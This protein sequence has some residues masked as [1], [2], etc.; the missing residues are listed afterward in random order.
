MWQKKLK[1]CLPSNTNHKQSQAITSNHKQSQER[2][3]KN[4]FAALDV[5][6]EIQV[7]QPPPP[8][9]PI[10]M[11]PHP[12]GSGYDLYAMYPD[13]KMIQD[14]MNS[15]MSWYDIFIRNDEE[16]RWNETDRFGKSDDWTDIT[17]KK[18]IVKPIKN[19]A[20]VPARKAKSVTSQ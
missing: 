3:S 6:E 10:K 12:S 17:K 20:D 13:M 15:G 8:P 14:Q 2:M 1:P 19:K 16:K 4:M 11:I 9:Q 18:V 7:T 5:E